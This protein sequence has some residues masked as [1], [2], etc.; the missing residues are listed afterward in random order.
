MLF[1]I[2]LLIV[3]FFLY[4]LLVKGILWKLIVA[5]FGW[6]GMFVALINYVPVSKQLCITISNYKFSW[7]EIIPTVIILLAMA[8]SKLD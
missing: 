2:I 3:I 1:G 4:Q 6:F 7:A 8:Y 5:I